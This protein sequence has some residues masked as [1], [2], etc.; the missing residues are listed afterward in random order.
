MVHIRDIWSIIG[1]FTLQYN[2]R[3]SCKLAYLFLLLCKLHS[4]SWYNYTNFIVMQRTS[5]LQFW[6]GHN[7]V[8]TLM[9]MLK[10]AK[11]HHCKLFVKPE[12]ILCLQEDQS[13]MYMT[14]KVIHT[15]VENL[16]VKEK[17]SKFSKSTKTWQNVIRL[18]FGTLDEVVIRTRRKKGQSSR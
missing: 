8:P 12:S 10:S 13:V 9:L 4:R 11:V 17:N 7:N 6:K 18:Q 15:I 16:L 3:H 5:L 2:K 14:F 1:V